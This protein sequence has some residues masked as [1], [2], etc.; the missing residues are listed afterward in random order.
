M[1]S[2]STIDYT[3]GNLNQ[4]RTIYTGVTLKVWEIYLLAIICILIMTFTLNPDQPFIFVCGLIFLVILG[5]L[6]WAL[7]IIAAMA[8]LFFIMYEYTQKKR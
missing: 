1:S 6:E 2:T 5:I 4:T 7:M 8:L 3:H